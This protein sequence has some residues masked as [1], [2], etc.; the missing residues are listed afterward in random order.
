MTKG[1]ASGVKQRGGEAVLRT[2]EVAQARATQKI[3][4]VS[5]EAL[6]SMG[7]PVKPR[8]ATARCFYAV[9]R[10]RRE[11]RPTPTSISA[12]RPPRRSALAE[13]RSWRGA[14]GVRPWKRPRAD[15]P[16]DN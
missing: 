2:R 1:M 9:R 6:G 15:S 3:R 12:P 5:G 10:A 14:P 7:T 16:R 11:S 4:P 13:A 8:A